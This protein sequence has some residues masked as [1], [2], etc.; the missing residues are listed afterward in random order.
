MESCLPV[1]EIFKSINGEG[2][3]A[4]LPSIFIRL[5]GC[6]LRCSYC[7]T[8]YSFK[9]R[10]FTNETVERIVEI[11]VRMRAESGINRITLTGGEPLMHSETGSLIDSLYF[12]S[13]NIEVETN[14]T[15]NPYS[16]DRGFIPSNF[17]TFT[18]DYK[19]GSSG[20][21][22]YEAQETLE[23]LNDLKS[24]DAI[25]FVVRIQDLPEVLHIMKTRS[26]KWRCR[27]IFI[28]PVWGDIEPERLVRFVID[29]QLDMRVQLQ[30]HKIIWDPDK[31]GV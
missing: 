26:E 21:S 23:N 12:S 9:G 15:F 5:A 13:F 16:M 22:R 30:L 28:S 3:F 11:A 19:C 31:R 7:D 24:S 29:N 1:V 14:G 17:I 18:M 20:I 10:N 25:K 2:P 8:T 27:N 6:N 4:G